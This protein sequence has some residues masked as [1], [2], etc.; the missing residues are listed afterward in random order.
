VIEGIDVVRKIGQT[1][2]GAQD[3]PVTP[4]TIQSVTI[5]RP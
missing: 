1:K 3:R 4:I 2:T 5:E